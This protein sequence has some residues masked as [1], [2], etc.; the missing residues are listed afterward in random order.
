MVHGSG[1][2][3]NDKRHKRLDCASRWMLMFI[4]VFFSRRVADGSPTRSGFNTCWP[5]LCE[6]R[7]TQGIS[8][9]R[10]SMAMATEKHLWM[11]H[12]LCLVLFYGI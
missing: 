4:R 12:V 11:G 7:G 6:S 2:R 10:Q 8:P 1:P 5:L 3:I 9:S